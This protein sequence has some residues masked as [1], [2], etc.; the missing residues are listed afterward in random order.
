VLT[1]VVAVI[2]P[3]YQTWALVFGGA[4][5]AWASFGPPTKS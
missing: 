2:V 5:V 3:G 1:V 4:L